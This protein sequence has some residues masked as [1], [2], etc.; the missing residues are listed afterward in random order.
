M[1]K[2]LAVLFTIIFLSISVNA[3]EQIYLP[4]IFSEGNQMAQEYPIFAINS[5]SGE[6]INLLD[7][8]S[9]ITLADPY[10]TPNV[11]QLKGGG[12]FVNP[13]TATG[14]ALVAAE[15]D[16]VIETI[17][18]RIHGECGWQTI[19]NL[20]RMFDLSVNAQSYWTQI[21]EQDKVWL[22]IR[23]KGD[24]FLTGYSSIYTISIPNLTSPYSSPFFNTLDKPQFDT[25]SIV[26]ERE[27]FFSPLEPGEIIGPLYNLIKNPD[28]ELWN[29]GVADSQP[30]SWDNLNTPSIS[31]TNNRD[32]D[33]KWGN[34]S[35]RVD[36]SG[37]SAI[38][39]AKGVTQVLEDTK[40]A[41][42]Y[43]IL[44]WVKSEGIGNGVGRILI[45]YS[46][47]LELYRDSDSHDWQ[48]YSGT[49]TTGVDDTVS[50]N[51]EILS[52]ANHTTGRIYFDGLMLV[53]GDVEQY[54]ADNL[55]GYMTSSH[56]VNHWDQPESGN[57]G[58]GDINFVDMWNLPGDVDAKIRL[59][60]KNNNEP[61]DYS[62][63]I[64]VYE[65]I[66]IGQ[67]RIGN[68][69]NF[70]N[71]FDYDGV[72]DTTGSSDN[73]VDTIALSADYIEVASGLIVSNI[74]DNI[75]KYK[76]FVRVYDTVD[77]PTLQSRLRY[78]IDA[79]NVNTRTL[80]PESA[81]IVR[82]WSIID[83]TE[84]QTMDWQ[85]ANKDITPSQIGFNVD[86][87]RSSGT[88]VGRLDYVFLIPT[89]GG[90]LF[91]DVTGTPIIFN[92]ILLVDSTKQNNISGTSVSENNW[93]K[94]FE[95]DNSRI[96]TFQE[97]K[98]DLYAGGSTTGVAGVSRIYRRRNNKW[99]I[100][101]SQIDNGNIEIR[102][103][104]VYN[105]R[106]YAGTVNLFASGTPAKI[107][108]SDDGENWSDF[109]NGLHNNINRYVDLQTFQGSLWA[110]SIPEG[111][112]N[113]YLEEYDGTSWNT[114]VTFVPG[115]PDPFP[116]L[117]E[118]Y[119][120]Q[121]YLSTTN[122]FNVYYW[123]GAGLTLSYTGTGTIN[124]MHVFNDQ[125]Y[126]VD[127]PAVA[128]G[129]IKIF[130]GDSWRSV[131]VDNSITQILGIT[132][133]NN[134]LYVISNTGELYQSDDFGETWAVAS[135]QIAG[136]LAVLRPFYVYQGLL[137]YTDL[138]AIYSITA[139][140]DVS[141]GVSEYK[142]GPF[143]APNRTNQSDSRHRYVFNY[144]REN[145]VNDIDDKALIGIGYRPR[146]FSLI[147]KDEF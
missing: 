133:F 129:A 3:Q 38:G 18:L 45:N 59:E 139:D 100:V 115:A 140:T 131:V 73:R 123:N 28:F 51:C 9:G 75:G 96:L 2:V 46:N 12:T 119:N 25:I 147:N 106:L 109:H 68:V 70:V 103:M 128:D 74:S 41:T 30:D 53:E 83:L 134:L 127:N 62:N 8:G 80:N 47:Q 124:D 125:L 48:L 102:S 5:E 44:A 71:Y 60:I 78:Y 50:V 65:K 81:P 32:T 146:Y 1:R 54:A 95:P 99:S 39:E 58:A 31:G 94:E 98:G 10:W 35:L 29:F 108:V 42:T 40:N 82:N 121:L 145:H 141:F 97:F 79:A 86:F 77:S 57:I 43:T 91:A 15:Y 84:N 112:Q 34:N 63:P 110:T 111:L 24:N 37:S 90:Y 116:E 4:I 36:V 23:A 144:D 16:N 126:M 49:I 137:F 142:G 72:A 114:R 120:N 113:G 21:Y 27:P 76:V 130:D 132:D 69:F 61:T 107:I 22:E 101:F 93:V 14:R 55:I 67:R 87:K 33:S 66:R 85:P 136:V 64:A 56:I 122:P 19:R 105:G 26:I 88:D 89:D 6:R 52:T 7:S 17:P 117:L 135:N 118:V 104:A 11:A 20:R 143:S 13:Q 92:H 138:S